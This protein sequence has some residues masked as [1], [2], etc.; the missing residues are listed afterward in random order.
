[1]VYHH[2]FYESQASLSEEYMQTEY[3]SKSQLSYLKE[4]ALDLLEGNIKL[5]AHPPISVTC[6]FPD[7]RTFLVEKLGDEATFV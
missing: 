2:S 6:F 4:T 3:Q 5:L 1:M 7:P